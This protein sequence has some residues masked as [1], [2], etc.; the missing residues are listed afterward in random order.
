MQKGIHYFET[1]AATPQ[2]E[3]ARILV[4][5]ALRHNWKR[6]AWDVEL[7]YAWADLP[8]NER[9]ALAYPKGCERTHPETGEPLY[10]ILLKNLYGDPAAGRRWSIH[11]DDT[12]LTDFNTTGDETEVLTCKRTIMDPCLF[13]IT[14]KITGHVTTYQ[15]LTSIHT[16]DL[17]AIGSDDLILDKFFTKANAIWTLKQANP[18]FMLGI[19]KVPL[20]SNDGTLMSITL[21]MSAFVRGA[22][23]AFKEHLPSKASTSPYP[24]K[25][26]L[27]KDSA[28][29]DLEIKEYLEKGYPRLIGMLLWAVRHGFDECKYGM[30]ILCS[31]A[32]RPGKHAWRNAMYMLSW[33]DVNAE[34]GIRFN[35][36]GNH[37][38]V[39]FSD[40]SEKAL[41]CNG[42]AMAGYVIMWMDGPLITSSYRL[43][44]VGLSSEQNEYMAITAAV[45]KLVWLTQLLEEIGVYC[46][47]PIEMYG[48]NVQANRLCTENIITPGNQYIAQYYHF[49]KEK[50]SEGLMTVIWVDTTLNIADI[51]TKPLTRPQC[52]A[53]M[54]DL[55][56]YGGGIPA[57][58]AK[59]LSM[60]PTLKQRQ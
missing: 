33:I 50:V 8:V 43:K 35:K 15:M 57:L 32:S 36:D 29:T 59:I 45:K 53:L 56:G 49:N 54:P 37:D 6:R 48:D 16:D 5:I 34:R 20:Y 4:C 44:H 11:R 10:I 3:T 25:D 22:V 28:V 9:L 7:A 47:L 12:L 2:P 18:N 52:E 60:D 26:D 13:Y 17:D 39:A 42:K 27:T 1:Y 40:A 31:V 24:P 14:L 38:I 55:L 23:E 51:Y 21:K 30:S 19:E 58:R 41:L 46:K